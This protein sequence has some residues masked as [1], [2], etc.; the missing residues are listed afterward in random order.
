MSILQSTNYQKDAREFKDN[1]AKLQSEAQ[2]R[3]D[4]YYAPLKDTQKQ[5]D[6]FTDDFEC[7][8]VYDMTVVYIIIEESRGYLDGNEDI[9]TVISSINTKERLL[10][11]LFYVVFFL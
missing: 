2:D 1:L 8:A 9:D 5:V 11:S 3:D 7:A 4:N 6:S 10:K